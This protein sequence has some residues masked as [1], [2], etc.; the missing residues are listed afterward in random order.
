MNLMCDRKLLA[1]TAGLAVLHIAVAWTCF[2]SF[3]TIMLAAELPSVLGKAT[4][5]AFRDVPDPTVSLAG[6]SLHLASNKGAFELVGIEPIYR[7]GDDTLASRVYGKDGEVKRIEARPGY[8]IGA[9]LGQVGDR[10]TGL[11]VVF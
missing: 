1:W 6:L 10:P 8:A 9:I 4:G 11:R 3:T 5:A 7:S 2:F